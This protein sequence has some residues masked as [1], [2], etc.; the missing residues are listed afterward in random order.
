MITIEKPPIWINIPDL[1]VQV[2]IVVWALCLPNFKGIAIVILWGGGWQ[3]FS[4]LVHYLLKFPYVRK[5]KR[6][7]HFAWSMVTLLIALF[8]IAFFPILILL[9]F[10]LIF[11]GCILFASYVFIDIDELINS[12]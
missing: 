4:H 11:I 6:R 8:S 1:I 5:T 2:G 10:P 7:R 12:I 3:L 9:G